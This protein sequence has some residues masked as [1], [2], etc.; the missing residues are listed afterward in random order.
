MLECFDVW[1]LTIQTKT[2]TK[3]ASYEDIPSATD[4]AI[5]FFHAVIKLMDWRQY[6][7]SPF[8]PIDLTLLSDFLAINKFPLSKI[9]NMHLKFKTAIPKEIEVML[10]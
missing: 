2:E 5:S 6:K 7:I 10:R 4:H 1:P 3:T 9:R 8:W